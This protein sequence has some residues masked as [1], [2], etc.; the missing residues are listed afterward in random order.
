MNVNYG[1]TSSGIREECKWDAVKKRRPCPRHVR[2]FDDLK[3]VKNTTVLFE[4]DSEVLDNDVDFDA[5]EK[6]AKHE[7]VALAQ[8]SELPWEEQ[9]KFGGL[10][11]V[12]AT[13]WVMERHY[14]PEKLTDKDLNDAYRNVAHVVNVVEA[15]GS[16]GVFDE[17]TVGLAGKVKKILANS[18]MRE[19]DVVLSMEPKVYEGSK[20]F[21][22][23]DS[24][25]EADKRK[26]VDAG[27][28]KVLP[29]DAYV[30]GLPKDVDDLLTKVWDSGMRN[31]QVCNNLN[32]EMNKRFHDGSVLFPATEKPR[33]WLFGKLFS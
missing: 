25:S 30:Y 9:V 26:Q 10:P 5:Y 23:K 16:G 19:G 2:H 31:S 33:K 20:C 32:A 11:S 4:D 12:Q 3:Q 7:R 24:V 8:M 15:T 27:L 13:W 14:L 17:Y 28:V 18:E 29:D 6:H 22:M 21:M 1:F